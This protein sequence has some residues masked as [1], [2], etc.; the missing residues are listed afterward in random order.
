M[1]DKKEETAP[2]ARVATRIVEA[3]ANG[4]ILYVA[5]DELSAEAIGA[6]VAMITPNP[7]IH[8]PSSDALPGDQAPA[9]PANAGRRVSA[10]RML[11]KV[12]EDSHRSSVAII[13]GAEAIARLY[14]PPEAFA[15]APP[16]LVPGDAIDAVSLADH[17]LGIGYF[18]DDRID[19]P[20][21]I[22]VRG[23]VIDLFPADAELPV[24][25]E[26]AGGRI[27]SLRAYDPM[28][29]R[30]V[31]ELDR[32]EVGRA[33]EPATGDGV[34]LFAHLEVASVV[35]DSKAR[36][37]RT[38]FKALADEA[39]RLSGVTSVAVSDKVWDKTLADWAMLDW[40]ADD[41]EALPRF[42]ER[43]APGGSQHDH[44]RM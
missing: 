38:Q 39:S 22:A 17:L 13:V 23:E 1:P 16:L 35:F 15:A 11:R 36:A 4:N 37:R 32:V 41:S 21:E 26:I 3:L 34:S 28:S 9:S 29:Q 40:S 10:F 5:S 31:V 18:V 42:V 2:L 12:S 14:P 25:I 24:R 7:V 8:L 6:A 33:A 30:T 43:K 20:G 27:A 19:E 44:T